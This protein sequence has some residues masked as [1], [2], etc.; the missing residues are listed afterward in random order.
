MAVEALSQICADVP[1]QSADQNILRPFSIPNPRTR[2]QF[3][4]CVVLQQFANPTPPFEHEDEDEHED[5]H[6][7]W[8]GSCPSRIDSA[9]AI[10][11]L[12]RQPPP[13]HL[14]GR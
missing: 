11:E 7:R 1:K 9:V 14:G 4:Q 5:Q 3:G 8:P 12:R 6:E 10:A 13:A 2:V